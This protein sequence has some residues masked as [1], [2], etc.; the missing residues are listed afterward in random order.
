MKTTVSSLCL[1]ILANF[2]FTGCSESSSR[3]D[4]GK[5]DPFGF[6]N[7]TE[8]QPGGLTPGS[9]T[10]GGSTAFSS[11]AGGSTNSGSTN[12]GSTVAG[13]T[14]RGSTNGALVLRRQSFSGSRS[15]RATHTA[16]VPKG[17]KAEGSDFWPHSRMYRMH[18][19][20]RTK[21]TA[22]DGRLVE[23]FPL[24]SATELNPSQE[25]LRLGI[26]PP[27]ERSIDSGLVVLRMPRTLDDWKTWVRKNGVERPFSGATNIR[28]ES[29]T[30]LPGFTK[31]LQTQMRNVQRQQARERAMLGA[32]PFCGAAAYA[33]R[34]TYEHNGT[35]WEQLFVWGVN[36][37]GS[38][39]KVGMQ[40]F[41]TITPN[42]T[43]RAPAGKLDKAM[44]LLMTI[45][46]SI[47]ATQYWAQTKAN[48]VAR[49]NRMDRQA[50]IRNTRRQTQFSNDMRKIITRTWRTTQAANDRGHRQFI[51][52]LRET[53][54]YCVPNSNQPPVQLPM[55]YKHI[56][57]SEDGGIYLSNN[58][59]AD[60]RVGS[61]KTWKKMERMR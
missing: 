35:K 16:L 20:L 25:M 42:T 26:R 29:I 45:A 38:H 37:V 4:S 2:L 22:P 1:I 19:S 47:R 27:R 60:P 59:N 6:F 32:R 23:V 17:W 11:P 9:P 61:T 34:F 54:N 44:P 24:F 13:S 49:Q 56:W 10:S 15:Q 21:V 8:Q 14:G 46:N 39:E 55:H 12:S 53:D 40:S 7:K 33:A 31:Y 50:F 57:Q 18:P 58:P 28:C 30:V 48:H 51:R 43:F 5:S 41:W 36:V 3:A 52:G